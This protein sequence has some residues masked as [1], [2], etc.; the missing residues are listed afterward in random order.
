MRI[1]GKGLCLFV[2]PVGTFRLDK[3]QIQPLNEMRVKQWINVQFPL[4]LV[5][6]KTQN[7]YQQILR[8]WVNQSENIPHLNKYQ[9]KILKN[10]WHIACGY[11]V[12]A[13]FQIAFNPTC[14]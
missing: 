7:V 13:F 10:L 12:S 11:N 14:G 4:T 2:R 3:C 1:Y 8:H 5:G 6:T 9:T